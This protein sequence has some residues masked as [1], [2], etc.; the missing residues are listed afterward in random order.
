[1]Q[2]ERSHLVEASLCVV[3]GDE[4]RAKRCRG[5]VMRRNDCR[6]ERERS[7]EDGEMNEV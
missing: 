7:I 1:M 6:S 2:F 5:L 4:K 3:G